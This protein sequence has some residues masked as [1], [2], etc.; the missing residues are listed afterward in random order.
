MHQISEQGCATNHVFQ[1]PDHSLPKDRRF[2]SKLPYRGAVTAAKVSPVRKSVPRS[3]LLDRSRPRACFFIPPRACFFNRV[4]STVSPTLCL[5][6]YSNQTRI[7]SEGPKP[8]VSR[9][10][11]AMA[12]TTIA[13]SPWLRRRSTGGEGRR[14]P[15]KTPSMIAIRWR[16]RAFAMTSVQG[17]DTSN[18]GNNNTGALELNTVFDDLQHDI[19]FKESPSL[20]SK[21]KYL[22]FRQ[23]HPWFF[24][25]LS[26]SFLFFLSI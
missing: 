10:P 15:T 2:V 3:L 16:R 1:F 11:E 5:L 19:A 23:T 8:F 25:F 26:F 24:S 9:T 6:L 4:R 14:K 17:G 13:R 21:Q 12:S 22:I 20:P 18:G 7:A